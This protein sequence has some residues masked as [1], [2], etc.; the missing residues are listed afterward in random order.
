MFTAMAAQRQ[1]SICRWVTL[2]YG[3][4]VPLLEYSGETQLVRSVE[5]VYN[6]IQM[7]EISWARDCKRCKH[8]AGIVIPL[9]HNFIMF[10]HMRLLYTFHQLRFYI[11]GIIKQRHQYAH[12][13]WWKT[14]FN[15]NDISEMCDYV[16]Q[17][18][19]GEDDHSYSQVGNSEFKT[20][21]DEISCAF[22]VL[23]CTYSFIL[24][25]FLHVLYSHKH[26][27]KLYTNSIQKCVSKIFGVA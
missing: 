16:P 1:C 4:V 23:L 24:L 2:T 8:A 9:V 27:F 18:S 22:W 13:I 20:N 17:Q 25:N 14:W 21:N 6:K 3:I 11:P 26:I 10:V 12:L 7:F 5:E 15:I 19:E